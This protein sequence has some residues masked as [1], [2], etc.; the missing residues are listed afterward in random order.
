ML[1][2]YFILLIASLGTITWH[3]CVDHKL[4]GPIEC[5]DDPVVLELVS[6]QDSECASNNGSIEVSATGGTGSYLFKIDGGTAQA[7]SFFPDLSA[8]VYEVSAEDANN[9]S[10]ILEVV[11]KN[12]GG[13]SI[14]FQTTAAGCGTSNGSII[15][16]ASEGVAPYTFKIN[17]SPF[18]ANNTFT[19]LDAGDQSVIV[20]DETGCEIS[21]TVKVKSGVSYT[22]SIS[23]I[24]QTNCVVSGCHNGS[25]FPD[26]RVFKN[27]Q[28]NAAQIKTLTGNRTMPEEGSL[29]QSE[30]DLIACWVDDGT[31]D[32]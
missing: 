16:T 29:T 15:V 9:C 4:P 26:F 27:I 6:V 24:I 25:Q 28:D 14:T 11:V 21:Q 8:G 3:G 7:A 13:L 17:G 2:K 1:K 10:A 30:I 5:S 20:R 12:E 22:T 19:G 18:S 23:S 32:N 31:P